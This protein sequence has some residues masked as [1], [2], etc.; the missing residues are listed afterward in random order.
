MAKRTNS[1]S[2]NTPPFIPPRKKIISDQNCRDIID[3]KAK[4]D[5]I[6]MAP[7]KS[8][9]I[10]EFSPD[11]NKSKNPKGL[12]KV[13]TIWPPKKTLWNKTKNKETPSA[14]LISKEETKQLEQFIENELDISNQKLEEE[15]RRDKDDN[16]LTS[17]EIKSIID[18]AEKEFHESNKVPLDNDTKLTPSETKKMERFIRIIGTKDEFEALEN[19]DKPPTPPTQVFSISSDDVEII[20]KPTTPNTPG[21]ESIDENPF[22]YTDIKLEGPDQEEWTECTNEEE[23]TYLQEFMK[24]KL[25]DQDSFEMVEPSTDSDDPLYP[26]C[27]S[28]SSKCPKQDSLGNCNHECPDSQDC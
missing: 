12:N 11:Y 2:N 21:D 5:F 4:G 3:E 1:H 17:E 22:F 27:E 16:K 6:Y 18:K 15:L 20:D 19:L 23:K 25:D 9:I 8:Q 7:P 14:P 26:C 28:D 13:S 24:I 10:N